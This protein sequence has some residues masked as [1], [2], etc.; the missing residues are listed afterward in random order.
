[1][2]LF[3]A[4][5]ST[6]NHYNGECL[7]ILLKPRKQD[8]HEIFSGNIFFFRLSGSKSGFRHEKLLWWEVSQNAFLDLTIL[9][10]KKNF[11]PEIFRPK[12]ALKSVPDSNFFFLLEITSLLRTEKVWWNPTLTI[13]TNL[14]TKQ[15]QTE[16]RMELNPNWW[17]VVVY[18]DS[19]WRNVVVTTVRRRRGKLWSELEILRELDAKISNSTQRSNRK[20]NKA[21]TEKTT[22]QRL[23]LSWDVMI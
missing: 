16:Q 14:A 21:T 11:T 4:L 10:A 6:K 13:Q 12:S 1:M 19:D 17:N 18:M 3:F 5:F 23:G 7:K 8:R 20:F 2:A 9:G 22:G 15:T